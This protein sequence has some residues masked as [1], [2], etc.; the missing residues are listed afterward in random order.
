MATHS[1]TIE[2][3]LGTRQ[4]IAVSDDEHILEVAVRAGID[5]PYSCLQGW[6]LTCAAKL[7]HGRVNQEDSRRYYSADREAGFA[8]LCTGR[9]E[10]DLSLRSHARDEMRRARDARGLPYPRGEWGSGVRQTPGRKTIL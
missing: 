1:V 3:R 8:L 5:L 9:P 4:T 6:C 10:S 2:T 7:V